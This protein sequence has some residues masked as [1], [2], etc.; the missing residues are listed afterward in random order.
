MQ[1]MRLT[2]ILTNNLVNEVRVSLQRNDSNVRQ[3]GSFTNMQVGIAPIV[4][5][6]TTSTNI[7]ISGL[8][9]VGTDQVLWDDKYAY[10]MGACDHIS[11]NHGKHTI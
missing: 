8:F 1:F 11:W 6:S 3:P 5:E 10:R 4:R 9:T 7:V 2:S